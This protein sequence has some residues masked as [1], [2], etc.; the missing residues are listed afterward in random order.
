MNFFVM[1]HKILLSMF[2]FTFWTFKMVIFTTTNMIYLKAFFGKSLFAFLTYK[3]T[4]GMHSFFVIVQ[5][6]FGMSSMGT[7]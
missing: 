2:K 7:L 6:F 5:I 3:F 1:C 4:F